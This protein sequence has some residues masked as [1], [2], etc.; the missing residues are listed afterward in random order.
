[1]TETT[2]TTEIVVDPINV[3]SI[4]EGT[5]NGEGVFDKLM[6]STNSHLLHEFSKNRITG[7]DYGKIYLGA[8]Q[9]VMGQAVQFEL[10]RQQSYLQGELIKAQVA[11]LELERL[12]IEKDNQL[13][14]KQ[15][16]KMDQEILVLEQQVLQS[17]QEVNKL[18]ADVLKTEAEVIKTEAE[19][20]LIEQNT[21]NAETQNRTLIL[22]Q[23]KLIAEKDLLAHKAFTEAAQINDTVNGAPVEGVIG[24]QKALYQKQA[25]GFDRDAEQKLAKIY[26]DTWS[27]R[28]S[29]DPDF[30]KENP[31]GLGDTDIAE[32]MNIAKGGIK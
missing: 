9:T 4:T 2:E 25:D 21:L 13:K 7:S 8:L 15:I 27:V 18:K 5:I 31:A 11:N 23:D 22:G 26:V 28:K 12:G 24:K 16:E 20:K 17:I 29:T 3:E 1:M 19:V 30:T 32:V 10:Q 14:D 6:Q